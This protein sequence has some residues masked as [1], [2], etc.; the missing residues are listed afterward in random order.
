MNKTIYEILFGVSIFALAGDS[1][2]F[3]VFMVWHIVWMAIAVFC[4]F[5]LDEGER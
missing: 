2:S 3:V 5:K 1:E 4:G